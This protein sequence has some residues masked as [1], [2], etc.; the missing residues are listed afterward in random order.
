[1]GRG[2]AQLIGHLPGPT[3][4]D[5]SARRAPLA[6][7]RWVRGYV[8]DVAHAFVLAV[9][10][11]RAAGS[12]Y[13]VAYP[14]A[15]TEA[16][17]VGEIGRVVGW[18][19]EIVALPASQLAEVLRRDRFDYRQDF[20][21]DSS[22]IRAELGYA[23]QVEFDEALRRTVTWERANP[24]NELRPEDYDYEAEDAALAAR[25]LS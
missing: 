3:P 6:G 19:G 7:F 23:E 12:T 8:E 5:P 4:Q 10:D 24:P 11:P 16:D 15:H 13:N 20:V 9:S 2:P 25:T 22:R 1:V 14:V 18:K 21:V 17:W